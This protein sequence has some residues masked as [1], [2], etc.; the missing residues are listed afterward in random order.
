MR[1]CRGSLTM[2]NSDVRQPP[3]HELSGHNWTPAY[4]QFTSLELDPEQL[5]TMWTTALHAKPPKVEAKGGPPLTP[6]PPSVENGI[7]PTVAIF[8]YAATCTA[9][10]SA[11]LPPT[12]AAAAQVH[13]LNT[14]NA[15][16][17][18]G[19]RLQ[20]VDSYCHIGEHAHAKRKKI[21][22]RRLELHDPPILP[23]TEVTPIVSQKTPLIVKKTLTYPHM[24]SSI[25]MISC[26]LLT[27]IPVPSTRNMY[28]TT[29]ILVI[30][31]SW[32]CNRTHSFPPCRRW[33]Y[34]LQLLCGAKNGNKRFQDTLTKSL[35]ATSCQAF[36]MDFISASTDVTPANNLKEICT[37]SQLRITCRRSC[38]LVALSGHYHLQCQFTLTG[39]VLSPKLGNATNGD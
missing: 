1:T 18:F 29:H 11:I 34:V 31:S 22:S 39:L 13:A 28:V 10:S 38:K 27:L 36:N 17:H 25:P 15:A 5:A 37:P 24:I 23:P 32:K 19:Q 9:A 12:E 14:T 30:C 20:D 6:R 16:S 26:C 33:H 3:D 21:D 2:L 4:G 8:L 7:Q 35:P